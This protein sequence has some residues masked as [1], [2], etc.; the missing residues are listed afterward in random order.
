MNQRRKH[1]NQSNNGVS[2]SGGSWPRTRAQV[3]LHQ[4]LQVFGRL[5][6]R[7]SLVSW[8]FSDSSR[9]HPALDPFTARVTTLISLTRPHSTSSP[10]RVETQVMIAVNKVVVEQLHPKVEVLSS[11][12]SCHGSG[13]MCASRMGDK[14]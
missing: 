14:M 1:T 10:T 2:S 8:P 4:D 7:C 11:Q 9:T 5:I 12:R 13:Q 6:Q 3:V